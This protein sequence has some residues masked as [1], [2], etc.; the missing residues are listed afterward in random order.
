MLEASVMPR[1]ANASGKIALFVVCC[2]TA[3][4]LFAAG[5]VALGPNDAESHA[6]LGNILNWSGKFTHLERAMRL[7]PTIRS[8]T[9]S[10]WA[11]S[12]TFRSVPT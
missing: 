12:T 2:V 5:S 10:T 9:S 8:I 11:I 3:G 4:A 1:I 6:Q 7:N